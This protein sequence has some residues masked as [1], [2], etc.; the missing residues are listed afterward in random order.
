MR[1]PWMV[2]GLGV[3]ALGALTWTGT[4]GP[5]DD[6]SNTATLSHKAHKKWGFNLPA[7][8]WTKIDW[9]IALHDG[10]E[11]PVE[12]TGPLKLAVDTNGDGKT[13][14]EVKGKGGVLTLKGTNDSGEK[15]SY[16]VRLAPE[17]KTWK[18]SAGSTQSG[19]VE[20]V[21]VSLIDMNNNGRFDDFGADAYTVNGSNYAAFLSRVVNLKGKLYEFEPSADGTSVKTTPYTGETATLDVR[22]EFKAKAKLMNA[23]FNDGSYSFNFADAK[24]GLVVPAGNYK[25]KHGF[26]AKGSS[27]ATIKPGNMKEIRLEA[28]S[29]QTLEWGGPITGDFTFNQNGK[30]VEV[31]SD[32]HFYGTLGEEYADFAPKGGGPKIF[33]KEK[34]KDNV[35]SKGRFGST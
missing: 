22:S 21:K 25:L 4:A 31:K 12:Q 7:E 17:G 10:L 32:F 26:V 15:V 8:T 1:A 13:D 29:T 11:F 23:V 2:H 6:A 33:I 19:T 27:N 18:W 16:T 30:R 3:L 9:S 20:G 14:K 34:G 28:G 24:K 35:L 5:A